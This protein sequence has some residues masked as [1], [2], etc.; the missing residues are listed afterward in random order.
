M[1][2]KIIL[3]LYVKKK[4]NFMVYNLQKYLPI[5]KFDHKNLHVILDILHNIMI[6]MMNSTHFGD[7]FL[8]IS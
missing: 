8:M 3:H 1:C 5:L 7:F 6:N 2:I 4:N